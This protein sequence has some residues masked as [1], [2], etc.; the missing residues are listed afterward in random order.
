M[1]LINDKLREKDEYLE[2]ICVGG[3]VLEYWIKINPRCR[4][5]FYNSNDSIDRIIL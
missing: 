2:L 3:F 1:D 5:L 4:H